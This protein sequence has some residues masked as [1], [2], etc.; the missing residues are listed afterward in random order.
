MNHVDAA[1]VV[2]VGGA[3]LI[4]LGA[5]N[6]ISA[7]RTPA[8]AGRVFRG[9]QTDRDRGGQTDRGS[10]RRRLTAALSGS[11]TRWQRAPRPYD[12]L[13]VEH[14]DFDGTS[15]SVRRTWRRWRKGRWVQA[16]DVVI[17]VEPSPGAVAQVDFGYVG[18]LDDPAS[19]PTGLRVCD[20]RSSRHVHHVNLDG[21]I[22]G[23]LVDLGVEDHVAQSGFE[24]P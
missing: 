12:R 6:L 24:R 22:I 10:G 1:E 14:D 7:R 15:W 21:P 16:E 5:A 2:A 13:R 17:P 8:A 23:G 20:G 4:A 3:R 9:G 18:R 11:T 19:G